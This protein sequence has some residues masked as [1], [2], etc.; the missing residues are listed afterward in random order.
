MSNVENLRPSDEAELEKERK[1]LLKS[2]EGGDTTLT[3]PMEDVVLG[4]PFMPGKT[5][6]G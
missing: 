3:G 2:L 4:A 1:K 6:V 5:V